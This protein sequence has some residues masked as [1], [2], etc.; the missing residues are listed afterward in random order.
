LPLVDLTGSGRGLNF[1]TVGLWLL[2]R[3]GDPLPRRARLAVVVSFLNE[4]GY[5]ERLL[6][7]L[8]NQTEPADEVLLVDDGSS[9]GSVELAASFLE[10]ISGARLLRRE[11]RPAVVDRLADAPE[12]RAFQWGVSRLEGTWDIVAKLDG[13]LELSQGLLAEVRDRIAANARLGI[14]G[15]ELAVRNP[16]GALRLEPNP[17]YH[18]RGPN[19]FY[20]RECF[21]A[22]FP[23][24]TILGWDTI[25]D[26][27]ARAAGWTTQGFV[28]AS[29][30]SIHLRPTG[31]HDGRLRA[32]RRWGECAW[33]Y[34]AHPLWVLTSSLRRSLRPPVM[35][36]GASYLAGWAWA[37]AH[38]APHAD[39]AVIA[40]RRAEDRR[41]LLAILWPRVRA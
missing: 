23:L 36:G 3:P 15:S 16:D 5:L 29:G 41:R 21:E 31:S 27:R 8:E 33:G 39:E 9:D 22:I 18:V 37:A 19:K 6:E 12:L 35:L 26:I 14:T 38:R 7:S 30:P 34:G 20:R 40:S 28:P 13:D 25:D 24:P 32:C 1:D 4:A 2:S 17:S 11:A 10:R